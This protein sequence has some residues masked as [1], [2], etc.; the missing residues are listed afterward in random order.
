MIKTVR[1]ID[2]KVVWVILYFIE[3]GIILN[4]RSISIV[5]D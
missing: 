1:I 2:I 5:E 3:F 4:I